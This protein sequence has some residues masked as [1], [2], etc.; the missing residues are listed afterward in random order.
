M[1]DSPL[2]LFPVLP[3][4]QRCCEYFSCP[5]P[6]HHLVPLGSETCILRC[7]TTVMALT[8]PCNLPQLFCEMCTLVSM[9]PLL[10]R[11]LIMFQGQPLEI[12]TQYK[13]HFSPHKN[14]KL[15]TLFSSRHRV[16][17]LSLIT[18]GISAVRQ[19]SCTAVLR[20]TSVF[21]IVYGPH[22]GIYT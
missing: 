20:E 14:T 17:P 9:K 8:A 19:F 15:W 16:G 6:H 21:N 11:C 18:E 7:D 12:Q 13:N 3:R 22:A 5:F 1:D 4:G 10:S 2:L